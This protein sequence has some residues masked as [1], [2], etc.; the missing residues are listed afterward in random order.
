MAAEP[1][2]VFE[3]ERSFKFLSHDKM[4]LVW[5]SQGSDMPCGFLSLARFCFNS[6]FPSGIYNLMASLGIV[7]SPSNEYHPQGPLSSAL[8]MTLLTRTLCSR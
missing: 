7:I 1:C 5:I 3:F 6:S 4:L 8:P 2:K